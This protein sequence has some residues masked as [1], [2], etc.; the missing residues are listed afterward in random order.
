VGMETI[1]ES[2]AGIDAKGGAWEVSVLGRLRCVGGAFGSFGARG[3]LPGFLGSFAVLP[4]ACSGF[5]SFFFRPGF[6]A[7][8]GA[9]VFGA[10]ASEGLGAE[11]FGAG[12]VVFATPEK[13]REST[14]LG[15]CDGRNIPDAGR[16]GDPGGLLSG[17]DEF[18]SITLLLSS[19][20]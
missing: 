13:V 19:I 10:L 9:V 12:V 3:F 5:T 16:S 2:A 8:A 20:A 15:F 1:V 4:A 17:S 11:V 7:G 18:E 6:L 14:M